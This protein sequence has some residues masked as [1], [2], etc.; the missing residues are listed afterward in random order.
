[1]IITMIMP[2]D[3]DQQAHHGGRRARRRPDDALGISMRHLDAEGGNGDAVVQPV[4]S[5]RVAANQMEEQVKTYLEDAVV[6][7]VQT[8]RLASRCGISTRPAWH[9][10]AASQGVGFVAALEGNAPDN[11]LEMDHAVSR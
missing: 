11:A 5:V 10:D 9:L 4:R 8:T 2:G 3:D 6:D 7:G 1:M